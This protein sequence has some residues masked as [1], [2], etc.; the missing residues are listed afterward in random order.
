MR[1]PL[2]SNLCE[3][4]EGDSIVDSSTNM[5]SSSYL[6]PH[7]NRYP[8]YMDS[9]LSAM[10]SYIPNSYYPPSSMVPGASS[11]PHPYSSY[12]TAAGRAEHYPPSS[13]CFKILLDESQSASEKQVSSTTQRPFDGKLPALDGFGEHPPHRQEDPDPSA[14]LK[15]VGSNVPGRPRKRPLPPGKPPYSY[16][17]LICM[18]IANSPTRMKTL[19][20]I[21]EFIN[22]RFPYYRQSTKWHGSI[23]HNLTLNDCFKKQARRPGDKGHPWSIDESFEDMFDNGSLLRRRYRYKV[24][25]K[26]WMQNQERSLSRANKKAET[27]AH[28][29]RSDD[30]VN[31]DISDN[32]Q[33]GLDL[34]VKE[35]S[36]IEI[37]DHNDSAIGHSPSSSAASFTADILS[38]GSLPSTDSA[39]TSN[40]STPSS[41]AE[42]SDMTVPPSGNNQHYYPASSDT[43]AV[44]VKAEFPPPCDDSSSSSS[45]S[46]HRG[47]PPPYFY[48]SS[49]GDASRPDAFSGSLAASYHSAGQMYPN[50]FS[51]YSHSAAAA[52]YSSYFYPPSS[53]H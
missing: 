51:S 39:G 23:R 5:A 46:A 13:N 49:H 10:S 22:E 34:S 42:K 6:Y 41:P 33:A 3:A 37:S 8:P 50:Y 20:E 18:A 14:L 44:T 47:P 16:I 40:A 48:G 35:E 32:P 9:E 43:D 53:S 4:V 25:S 31:A 12:D 21:I 1:L 27:D 24:G 7:H 30:S 2:Y 52:G 36:N 11:M 17:A 45:F 26:R 28:P 19:R 29:Q 38:S 15:M